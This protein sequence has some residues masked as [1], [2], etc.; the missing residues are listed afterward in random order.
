M[1][2]I[3]DLRYIMVNKATKEVIHPTNVLKKQND[4]GNPI[5]V[6]L[7]DY[8]KYIFVLQSG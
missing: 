6:E 8:E 5:K 7:C 1:E 2:E 3:R 4:D